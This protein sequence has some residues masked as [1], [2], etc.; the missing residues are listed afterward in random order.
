MSYPARAWMRPPHK[1][2]G[3]YDVVIVGGGQSGLAAAFGLMRER[4]TNILVL[5]R[6]EPGREGPWITFARMITLRTPKMVTGLDFGMPALTPR[7]W[8]EA[9]WGAE[10]WD[11]ART[12]SARA[13]A[14]LSQLVSPRA[15]HCRSRTVSM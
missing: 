11:Q 3:V 7:A 13:M 2:R 6:N 12:D 15:R 5:D 4:V 10:A 14:G 8:F 1:P 9:Q